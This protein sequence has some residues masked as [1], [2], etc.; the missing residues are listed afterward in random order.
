VHPGGTPNPVRDDCGL[1]VSSS[2]GD[3]NDGSNDKPYATIAKALASPESGP[4]YLCAE[5]FAE[6]VHIKSGRKIYGGLDCA[7]DWKHVER[8]DEERG[9]PRGG[10][11]AARGR[12]QVGRC[13]RMWRCARRMR[14][15]GGVFYCGDR[16]DG[17]GRELRWRCDVEAGV[18]KDGGRD[19]SFGVGASGG[20]TGNVRSGCVLGANVVPGDS[21]T[22]RCATTPTRTMTRSAARAA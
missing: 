13:W 7:K 9:E 2:K 17:R 10:R 11:G 14:W 21:A 15:S 22:E 12:P 8:R 1:F 6:A 19:E 18:A 4:I 16:D 5:T 20:T 3:D